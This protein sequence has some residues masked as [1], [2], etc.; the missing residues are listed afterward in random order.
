MKIDECC[1]PCAEEVKTA[2]EGSCQE[3][4]I[5]RMQEHL[6]FRADMLAYALAND[7]LPGLVDMTLR[8]LLKLTECDYIA[9]HSVDGD[10]RMLYPDDEPKTCPVRCG[11]CAFYKLMIPPVEDA[12]HVIELNDAKGQSVASIP[13]DCP[14]KSLEVV[15]VYCEGKPWGGIALHYLN[16]QRKV[17]DND[18]A[19]LKNAANV[20]TLALE[21]HSAAARLKA[22]R[23]RV[24]EAEKTRSYFFS[25]V[26]HDI[27]TP[28]NAIIGF[29]ELLQSG[30]VSPEEAKQALKM[31][32]TSGKT[33][34]QLV[35][36]VLDLSQMD[37]G[38][39]EFRLEPTDVGELVRDLLPM[40]SQMIKDEGQTVVLEI[41]ELP[42]LMLDPH[43]FRQLMFNFIGNAVKYA[44][45]CTISVSLAYEGGTLKL[46][47][48]DNGRGVSEE[49]AKLLTQPF[50]Q[51]DIK[52]R[53][54]GSGLGLA[55]CRRLLE[56]VHGTISIDT[57]PGTGFSIR[58]E[59]PVPVASEGMDKVGNGASESPFEASMPMPRR[60]L[61][62]DD[63][64]V[65]RTVLKA[66]LKKLGV[67]DVELAVDGRAALDILERDPAFDVVLSDMWMPVMDGAE[68]VKRIR[69]DERLAKLKVCSVTADVEARATYRELGFD[70]LILKPM[71]I[72]KLAALFGSVETAG[73][74]IK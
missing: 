55:I 5:A 39:L 19:S 40:F 10:H 52:N 23:D 4:T 61:V 17:S 41:P 43:R 3:K 59:A 28:L 65:N 8:R 35:N 48:A 54:D 70:S 66:L 15:V 71:T 20:L 56:I 18:R 44:G 46:T 72:N 1:L 38:K 60:V 7:D 24:V 6:R 50:V 53:L 73:R 21:R 67:T 58:A 51:A 37:L 25:S 49:K 33:L 13:C 29:S 63:S 16:K 57:A 30:G 27:R 45:P 74:G 32:V 2:S 12:D 11:G 22:E 34:L 26:S 62:V 69:A 47:V 42:L 14:A 68:L 31:I 36:D 9:I 64:A